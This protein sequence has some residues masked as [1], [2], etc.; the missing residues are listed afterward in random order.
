MWLTIL[1]VTYLSSVCATNNKPKIKFL[2]DVIDNTHGELLQA[3]TQRLRDLYSQKK[4]VKDHY[5]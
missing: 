3:L 5:R 1:M 4:R 2:V